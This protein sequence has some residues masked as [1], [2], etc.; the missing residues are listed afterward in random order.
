ME[1]FSEIQ[2][3]VTKYFSHPYYVQFRKRRGKGAGLKK[4]KKPSQVEKSHGRRC[5]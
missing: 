3:H 5:V 1:L 2:N 4:H